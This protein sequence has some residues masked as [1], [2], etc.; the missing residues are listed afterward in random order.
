[1]REHGFHRTILKG[2]IVR[3]QGITEVRQRTQ[4]WTIDLL[5]HLD[6]EE[7]IFADRIVVLQMNHNVLLRR[8]L[9]DASKGVRCASYIRF[10]IFGAINVRAN[11]WGSECHGYVRPLIARSDGL[12]AL[13]LVQS[14][15]AMPA[16]HRD[17]NDT[18]LCL[19]YRISELFKIRRI[20]RR[21]DGAPRLDVMYVELLGDVGG[22]VFQ[23]H[24]LFSRYLAR[25]VSIPPFPSDD[26]LAERVRCYCHSLLRV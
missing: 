11:A 10:G 13:E 6:D 25:S 7:R 12:L 16:I 1:M 26:E 2:F 23:L 21:E 17:I 24:L 19:L 18:R 9:R 20:S 8:I 15:L 3:R 4:P 14:I 5:N 22:E